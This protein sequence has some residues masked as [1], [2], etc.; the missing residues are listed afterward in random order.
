MYKANAAVEWQ[1]VAVDVAS[2][3]A[4]A[5]RKYVADRNLCKGKDGGNGGLKW[6]SK[7]QARSQSQSTVSVCT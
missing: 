1:E 3:E 6:K 2:R 7:S 4:L 5:N